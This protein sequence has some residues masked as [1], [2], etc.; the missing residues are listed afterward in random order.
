MR[1]EVR[2]HGVEVSE[3]LR[4]HVERR[5]SFALDRLRERVGTV[6]VTLRDVNG[7]ERGGLDKECR[8]A[9]VLVPSGSVAARAMRA[10][11]YRAIDVAVGGAGRSVVRALARRRTRSREAPGPASP[12]IPSPGWSA[13]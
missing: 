9:V 4:A 10:D 12:A 5:L 11:L 3:P 8:V 7:G 13:P 1:V 6:H 2:G